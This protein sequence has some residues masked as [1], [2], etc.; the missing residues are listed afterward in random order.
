MLSFVSNFVLN[1]CISN[2]SFDSVLMSNIIYSLESALRSP[3]NCSDLQAKYIFL[4]N[5]ISVKISKSCIEL[6]GHFILSQQWI[7]V[8]PFLI[9]T[10]MFSEILGKPIVNHFNSSVAQKSCQIK[11]TTTWNA[12]P[13]E[14][15]SSRTVNTWS[16]HSSADNKEQLGQTLGRKSLKYP[17]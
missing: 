6:K 8:L 1:Y 9:S 14:V 15:V 11:I 12:L 10:Y 2:I 7:I 13:N 16:V 5:L 3:L 4:P 17:S